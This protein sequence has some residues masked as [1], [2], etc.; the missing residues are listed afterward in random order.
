MASFSA[1]D[2]ALFDA[3][4]I[5]DSVFADHLTCLLITFMMHYYYIPLDPQICLTSTS[6]IVLKPRRLVAQ[7]LFFMLS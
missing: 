4:E 6:Q 7:P 2:P 3:A 5:T 1:R